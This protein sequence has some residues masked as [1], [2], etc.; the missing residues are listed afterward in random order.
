MRK[1]INGM[2]RCRYVYSRRSSVSRGRGSNLAVMRLPF[3][4]PAQSNFAQ[5]CTFIYCAD[6]SAATRFWNGVLELPVVL[7]QVAPPPDGG[8]KC[9][10]FGVAPTGYVGA[11]LADPR[12][13]A[14]TGVSADGVTISF[15]VS[16]REEVDAWA[17]KL[18][19]RGVTL[20][21]PPTFNERY[22]IYH[23]FFR[24]PDKHLCEVQTF[25]DP[26]WP[27]A[28]RIS[29]RQCAS[30]LAAVAVGVFLGRSLR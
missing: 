25:L 26:K 6:L 7:D 12:S 20:E 21:K 5:L 24:D 27:S 1:N 4:H 29:V 28:P 18:T 8:L 30:L 17:R 14:G 23:I 11:V 22:N 2:G 13:K 9:R 3:T 19:E 16:S 15:T 10:I